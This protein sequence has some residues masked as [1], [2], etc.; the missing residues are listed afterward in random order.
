MP[1]KDPEVGKKKKKEYYEKNKAH[2]LS[3]VKVSGAVHRMALK[4]EVLTHYGK[5]KTLRCC[6]TYCGVTD[7][8]MLSIDHVNNDGK[9]RGVPDKER[10]KTA[11]WPLYSRLKREGYPE[12]FQTLCH[13]HQFKK[14]L[15]RKREVM[16]AKN[17]VRNTQLSL[18]A[19]V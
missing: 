11:G 1:Y 9:H 2:I 12:G 17:T 14:E 7:V 18:S 13:N 16:R 6:W 10:Y 4:T 3:S 19:A 15:L 8:D 5:D